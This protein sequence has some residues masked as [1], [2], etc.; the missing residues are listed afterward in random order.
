MA[1]S[2]RPEI[3]AYLAACVE[4]AFQRMI[5]KLRKD[6]VAVDGDALLRD[7]ATVRICIC[8]RSLLQLRAEWSTGG[9]EAGAHRIY[10]IGERRRIRAAAAASDRSASTAEVPMMWPA[11]PAE[12]KESSEAVADGAARK[13]QPHR[14]G[15]FVAGARR[16]TSD[17]PSGARRD[18]GEESSR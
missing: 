8:R 3:R 4:D 10:A 7:F 5:A 14:A 18:L 13:P 2:K 11:V 9:A 12:R 1:G 16:V 15:C 6:K 17:I